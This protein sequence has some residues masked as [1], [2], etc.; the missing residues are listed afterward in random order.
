MVSVPGGITS[1]TL[2]EQTLRLVKQGQATMAQLQEQLS[3][4]KKTNDLSNLSAPDSRNLLNLRANE[5]RREN[6]QSVIGTLTPRVETAA[7]SMEGMQT[8]ISSIRQAMNGA[9]NGEAAITAGL[10]SQAKNALSQVDYFMN[11]K[12]DGRFIFSGNRYDTPPLADLTAL[13][14]PP[15]EAYP[16]T[17]VASPA[18][19][20]YDTDYDAASPAAAIPGA[21]VRDSVAIDDG[22]N[23][24][25]G[26]T[27]TDPAFQ[28]MIQGLRYAYAASQDPAHYDDY[29]A[30][31]TQ[32]LNAA[33]TSLRG[34][35]STNASNQALLKTVDAR[36]DTFI[37]LLK[38]DQDAINKIDTNEVAAKI[39]TLQSQIEASYAATARITQLSILTYLR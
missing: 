17:A 7:A 23:V 3:T 30:K 32:L 20:L 16:F 1:I 8:L 22:L 37:S 35:Q 11:Q 12:I 14:S 18:V 19:P 38:T 9:S 28:Q 36:H 29:T 39:T 31:A 26:I 33:Q 24:T 2:Q 13:P 10:A 21:S 4:G 27:S 6:Y 5:S 15:A 34:V 25:Y